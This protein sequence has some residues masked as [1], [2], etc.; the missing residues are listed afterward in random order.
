M[1]LILL[2]AAALM[3][4]GAM[5][6]LDF[7]DFIDQRAAQL[8]APHL[9]T[10]VDKSSYTP[11]HLDFL[12]SDLTVT[13]TASE[14]VLMMMGCS[15]VYGNGRNAQSVVFQNADT[16]RDMAPLTIIGE[17]DT[18]EADS[19]YAPYML[20]V[21][22]GYQA[23]DRLVLEYKEQEYTFH[24]AGFVED[25]MLGA[26]N[27]GIMGFYMPEALFKRTMAG[28][29][30]EPAV[31]LS[32]QLHD[33]GQSEEVV[34]GFLAY[35]N[36]KGGAIIYG[37]S[38][39]LL[40]MARL[41]I[42][43]IVSMVMVAFAIIIT[44]AALIVIHFRISDTIRD[45][46]KDIGVLKA[47]G[48]TSRQIKASVLMQFLA[49]ALLAGVA[50]IFASYLLIPAVSGM[51]SSQ[52]GL[53][54]SHGFAPQT[55]ILCLFFMLIAVA[56]NVLGSLR[57]VNDLHPIMA[58]RGEVKGEG[59]KRNY[60]RLDGESMGLQF[61]L[62][63]KL[64][65]ENAGQ[66]IVVSLIIASITF[67]S[68]FGLVLYYNMAVDAE[69][70]IGTVGG[71]LCSVVVSPL[72][73]IQAGKLREEI[74]AMPEVAK[75]IFFD[76]FVTLIDDEEFYAD[77]TQDF[78]ELEGRMLYEGSYPKTAHET[79]IGGHAAARLGKHIGD[80]VTVSRGRE[81]ASFVITGLI[82]SGNNVGRQLLLTEE[83]FVQLMPEFTPS[84]IYVYLEAGEAADV[85][86]DVLDNRYGSA[87]AEPIN[88][89]EIIE[90]Q[91]RSYVTITA[92]MAAVVLVITGLIVFLI[93]Y[94]VIKTMI[95][96]RR[97]RFGVQKALGYTTY[98]IMQQ[99]ALS[100]LPVVL[101][102]SLLGVAL[103]SVGINPLVTALFRSVGIMRFDMVISYTWL[104]ALCIGLVVLAYAISMLISFRIRGIS[105]YL[106]V[107]E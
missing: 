54:W 83:G 32:A 9:I 46:R 105:A 90:G 11:A 34:K 19:I 7:G 18:S 101:G 103:G 99:V 25:I 84:E 28:G 61:S 94:F 37:F 8:N 48:Y 68:A 30:A 91:T 74:S 106:L 75:A 6:L 1:F 20:H 24:I 58:I 33:P 102:G 23:G 17:T 98:Q 95:S 50:G 12:A 73:N 70:F 86:V 81:E 107:T 21:G 64:L 35:C 77:I 15:F 65:M 87:I 52:S 41:M 51:F 89:E 67:A 10:I 26:S 63:G 97:R 5:T 3:S 79:A 72:G 42:V 13:Q 66:S 78:E 4:I 39:E 92:L 93:L 62:A 49:I 53:I 96:R 16:L 14:D 40:K 27:M 71:E 55:S 47:L 56:L 82:Q 31:L 76:S 80:M 38:I 88:M 2:I 57:Q 29:A 44:I 36:E 85:F 60:F 104:G 100:F 43:N 22:G 69:S 45:D 59:G